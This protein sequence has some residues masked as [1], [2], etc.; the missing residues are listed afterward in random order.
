[1][2]ISIFLAV[3]IIMFSL[4]FVMW[5]FDSLTVESVT[6]YDD[7]IACAGEMRVF[8]CSE[9]GFGASGVGFFS[10]SFQ[11]RRPRPHMSTTFVQ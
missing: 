1:M 8:M 9:I 10:F 5:H 3:G 11:I 2:V 6:P 7:N 4:G